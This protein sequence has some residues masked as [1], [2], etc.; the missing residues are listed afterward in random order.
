MVPEKGQ[1]T[2]CKR[3]SE[4]ENLYFPSDYILIPP[5]FEIFVI[6]TQILRMKILKGTCSIFL[7]RLRF[8]GQTT[9]M[10]RVIPY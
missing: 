6:S 10:I 5:S 7:P 3:G 4:F 1:K 8:T 2:V 9:L